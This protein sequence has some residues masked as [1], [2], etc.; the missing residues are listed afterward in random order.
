MSIYE[1]FTK[2]VGIIGIT[3]LIVPL[4]GLILL[5]II[6]KALGASGYGVWAQ[7]CVTLG[8]INPI[9]DL[10]LSYTFVRFFA[11]VK[12]KR[13]I[14]NAFFSILITVFCWSSLIALILF[15]LATP[16]ANVLFNDANAIDIVKL[17]AVIVPFSTINTPLLFFFRT[18]RQM[19]T[20]SA[21]TLL[22]SFGE[23]A[24]IAYFVLSGF[25]V[26]GA[27]ISLLI[28][29]IF[30]D[31]VML[32]IIVSQIGIKIPNFSNI[33]SYLKFGVPLIPSQLSSWVVNSSDRYVIV[34]FMGITSVGIYSAAYG[35]G[36]IITMFA[37]PL[38]LVLVPALS[39]SYDEGKIEEVKNLLAYSLKYL[40]MLSIPSAFGLSILAKPILL[41]MTTPEF[42]THG[43]LIVP[44]VALSMVVLSFYGVA[45][46]VISLVKKTRILGII[47]IIAGLVNLSLNI[48]FVPKIGILGAAITTLIAFGIVTT[49]TAYLS[50][51]YIT[52][53]IDW[54]FILKTIVASIVMCIVIRYINPIQ[55]LDVLL[56]IGIGAGIYAIILFLL[57]GFTREEIKFFK[58]ILTRE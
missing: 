21:L 43:R 17:T 16:I 37:A 24:A 52:F 51:K 35:I 22:Q 2:D 38:G 4:K 6:I 58:E 53:D 30:M 5:P 10:T 25:G 31:V 54:I 49:V 26:F 14:Q 34:F 39:K 11:G 7:V 3:N 8:L 13:E 1:K 9:A 36:S 32:G 56:C 29:R 20:F 28:V 23:M 42:V 47:W 44:F 18:Y 45:A 33:R 19:K 12:D 50:F 57:K 15:F 55:L 27:V 48:I 40:L 41:I 46:H